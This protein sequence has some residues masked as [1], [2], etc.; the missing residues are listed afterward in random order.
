M[1]ICVFIK[2]M[3]EWSLTSSLRIAVI[4]SHFP[5][6]RNNGRKKLQSEAKNKNKN[7]RKTRRGGSRRRD[8]EKMWVQ[9]KMNVVEDPGW[10]N[11]V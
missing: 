4:S 2:K 6:F 1:A 3:S 5:T 11:R 7:N 10:K 8:E 9:F